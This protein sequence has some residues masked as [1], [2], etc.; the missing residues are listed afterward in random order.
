MRRPANARVRLG[1][2][3]SICVDRPASRLSKRITWNPRAWRPLAQLAVLRMSC[4]PSP[5]ISSRAG[6]AGSPIVS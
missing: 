6:S 5:M 2:G 3:A 4:V 1:T